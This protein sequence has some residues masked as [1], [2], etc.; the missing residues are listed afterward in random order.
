MDLLGV[1]LAGLAGFH[2]LDRVVECRGPVEPTTERLAY[3]GA[4]RRVMP[5]IPAMY[6]GQKLVSLLP[7]DAPQRDIVRPFLVKLTITDAV[8]CGLASHTLCFFLLLRQGP[9]EQVRL[10]LLATS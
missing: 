3:E 5:A 4:R 6:V 2:Q 7:G 9:L 10:E 1:E 8:G